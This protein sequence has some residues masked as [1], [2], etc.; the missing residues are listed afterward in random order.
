MSNSICMTYS[1]RKSPRRKVTSCLE[2]Q[3]LTA[4][5]Q[6]IAAISDS[7]ERCFELN[8]AVPNQDLH[9]AEKRTMFD[10][11]TQVQGGAE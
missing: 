11:W 1:S 10:H 7:T 6:K 8:Q 2:F 9:R 4:T 5:F 3:S